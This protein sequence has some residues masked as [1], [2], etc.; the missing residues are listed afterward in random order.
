V[1]VDIKFCGICHSDLV[2]G[3]A[4]LGLKGIHMFRSIGVKL[5]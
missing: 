4:G 2:G 1:K 5:T 3:L